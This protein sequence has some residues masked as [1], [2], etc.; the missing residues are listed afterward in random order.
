M[1]GPYRCT[2]GI[3]PLKKNI[4][5]AGLNQIDRPWIVQPSRTRCWLRR[6]WLFD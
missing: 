6:R 3:L 4:Q 5:P 2:I 1:T